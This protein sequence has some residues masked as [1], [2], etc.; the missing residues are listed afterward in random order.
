MTKRLLALS[1][2]LT[3]LLATGCRQ[4]NEPKILDPGAMLYINVTTTQLKATGESMELT[5]KEIVQQAQGF[6]F[7]NPDTGRPDSPLGIG[8]PQRDVE[9]ARIKMWGEQI[10]NEKGE[11]E[12]YFIKIRDLRIMGMKDYVIGYVPNK[13]MEQA[14]IDIKREYKAGHYDEVYKLFQKAYTAIPITSAKWKALKE[15]GEQ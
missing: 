14:E 15:K 1:V 8:D 6:L 7:T 13:V 11:L 10:I 2:V 12:E 9:N 3:A 4:K 5:P